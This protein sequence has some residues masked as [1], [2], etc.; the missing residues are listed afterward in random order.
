MAATGRPPSIGDE[1]T[2]NLRLVRETVDLPP[3]RDLVLKELERILNLGLVQKLTVQVGQPIRYSRLVP[4]DIEI[5]DVPEE[6]ES[7]DLY[8]EARNRPIQDVKA[9]ERNPFAIL[10]RAFAMLTKEGLRPKAFVTGS[11]ENL[12]RWIDPDGEADLSVLF[13][14]ELHMN[15]EVPDDVLLLLGNEA[16]GAETSLSI[17]I[18]MDF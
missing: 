16:E 13:G 9:K 14:V 10:F 8:G 2:N 12:T 18:P 7:G 4:R 1:G 15:T 11:L 3:R 6:I 17:R 5:P